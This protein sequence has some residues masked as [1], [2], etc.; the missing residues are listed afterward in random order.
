VAAGGSGNGL[1]EHLYTRFFENR[2]YYKGYDFQH[3]PGGSVA[4]VSVTFAQK[5]RW[6]TWDRWQ[7]RK[8]ILAERDRLQREIVGMRRNSLR[9]SKP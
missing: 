7:R 9:G 2:E 4:P 3:A 5:L 8:Q 1:Y 6:W